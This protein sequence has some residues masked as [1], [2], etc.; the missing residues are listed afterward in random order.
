MGGI[1]P[2]SPM[3]LLPNPPPVLFLRLSPFENEEIKATI[4]R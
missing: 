3:Y 4:L 1:H 2:V